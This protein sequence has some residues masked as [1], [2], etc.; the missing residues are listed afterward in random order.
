MAP[1]AQA[2][3][4]LH[5]TTPEDAAATEVLALALRDL[6][7]APRC[8]LTGLPDRPG[9]GDDIAALDVLL[10]DQKVA[11]VVL[12]G[13]LL[14]VPLIER[15][16]ARGIPLFLVDCADPVPQGGWRI[17][18]GYARSILRRFT[19]IHTRDARATAALPRGVSGAVAV[20]ESGA[21]ARMAP[22]R[23]CNP[24]ELEELRAAVGTRPV[25]CAAA[26]P[27]AELPAVLEAQSTLLRRAP[28]LLLIV[29]P[30]EPETAAALAAG[31]GLGLALRSVDAAVD[32]ATQVYLADTDDPPGLFLRV[33]TVCYLGGSLGP[34]ADPLA[35]T[36]GAALGS[37]LVAG[38]Q[39]Q[40]PTKALT[41]RLRAVGGLH[42]IRAAADLPE[43]VGRLLSPEVGAQTALRAWSLVTAGAEA[44]LA[45]ARAIDDHLTLTEAP[46]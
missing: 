44:T 32:D 24:Q 18:P 36:E 2:C 29:Q 23:A 30:R 13:S 37:A 14:P 9:P 26:V 16:R 38:P 43:A 19:Q 25:W 22:A 28:R 5:A 33:A 10:T 1:R 8:V 34:G 15:A 20:H 12:V 4:W 21:L 6:P 3:V 31:S 40:G 46:R 39:A 41:D 17:L 42:E 35:T 27:Q 11:L 7:R 45:V